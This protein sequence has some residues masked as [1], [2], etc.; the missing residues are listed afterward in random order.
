[1]H[2]AAAAG[3][4]VMAIFGPENALRYGPFLPADKREIVQNLVSCSPCTLYECIAEH[5]RC[6]KNLEP[7]R[8]FAAIDALANRIGL[9]RRTT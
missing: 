5:H 2:L 9:D 6:L 7:P 8:V 3:T 4:P 1:M